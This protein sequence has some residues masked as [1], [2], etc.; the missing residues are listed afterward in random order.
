MME[1]IQQETY[2]PTVVIK[3]GI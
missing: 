3:T 1:F 2:Y